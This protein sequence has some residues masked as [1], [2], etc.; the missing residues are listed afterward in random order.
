MTMKIKRI[1]AREFLFV[2]GSTILFL[3]LSFTY[4]SIESNYDNRY[5]KIEEGLKEITERPYDELPY[6]LR[7]YHFL[8]NEMGEF[9]KVQK[10]ENEERFIYALRNEDEAMSFFKLMEMQDRL[11]V[12]LDRYKNNISIDIENSES[13]GYLSLRNSKEEELAGIKSSFFYSGPY[14]SVNDNIELILVF[15]IFFLFGLRYLFYATT[16]SVK[17]LRAR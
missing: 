1:I 2:L 3:I 15:L 11:N 5:N 7:I 17:Q 10:I 16:W 13:E 6:R 8:I 12:D 4:A 9:E 14:T